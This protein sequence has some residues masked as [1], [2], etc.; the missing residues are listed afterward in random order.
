MIRPILFFFFFFCQIDTVFINNLLSTVLQFLT[1]VFQSQV[2]RSISKPRPAGQRTDANRELPFS[3]ALS[4]L[5]DVQLF[6]YITILSNKLWIIG[7]NEKKGES[8]SGGEEEV[9][10]KVFL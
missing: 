1:F 4:H 7:V 3:P 10:P 5:L 8:K 9:I 2:W 6:D